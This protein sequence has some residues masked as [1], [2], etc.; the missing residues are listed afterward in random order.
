VAYFQMAPLYWRI[1]QVYYRMHHF[2]SDYTS[3]AKK[4][5]FSP[6]YLPPPS[7]KGYAI[8]NSWR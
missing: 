6:K 2:T 3:F 4:L 8:I 7:K 1:R 5:L